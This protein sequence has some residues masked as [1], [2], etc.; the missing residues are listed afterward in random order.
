M[1]QAQTASLH[2]AEEF[3]P[4]PCAMLRTDMLGQFGLY[5]RQGGNHV[6]YTKAGER[7]TERHR[8][9]LSANGVEQ[10]YIRTRRKPE[11]KEHVARYLGDVLADE[12]IP[13]PARARIFYET[14]TEIVQEVFATRLPPTLARDS[15]DRILQFVTEGI[16]FLTLEN[17]M[18]TIASLI[19]HDYSTYTHSI[20]VFVYSQAILQTYGFDEES[21]IQFGLGAM[22]HDIGKTAVQDCILTKPGPLTEAERRSV[23]LHPLTGVGLCTR[24]PLSQD[25]LHCILFHH[26][27][28]DGSGY[29][30]GL[31]DPQIPLPV[32]A[33]TIADIYDALT[34]HRPYAEARN[35]FAVLR[36][37]REEMHSQIDMDVFKRFVVILSGAS[38]I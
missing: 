27:K 24:M 2:S 16:G 13:L 23:N 38:V 29:P 35:P 26:E 15:F 20:H 34:S 18:G 33:I 10:V 8:R 5:I 37:M 36:L 11:Y 25:A 31:T 30:C 32:R 22:L 12:S 21:L 7:F 6:L 14:S 19:A 17:S 28:L 4:V 1:T 3:M 9:I